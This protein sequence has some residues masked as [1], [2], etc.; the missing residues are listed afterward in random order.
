MPVLC[1][2][3]NRLGLPLADI[4]NAQLLMVAGFV[5]LG[6]VLARRQLR[7]RK[8]VNRDTRAANKQLQAMRR[9]AEPTLPLS[10]APPETQRWQV[11][12]FDLQRELKAELDTRIAIV[13]TLVRQLDE[14]IDRISAMQ[15]GASSLQPDPLSGKT[16]SDHLSAQQHQAIVDLARAGYPAKEISVRTELPIGDV[17]IVLS[18]VKLN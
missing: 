5:M 2:T 7:M 9:R 14:R 16:G 13:N 11:A 10:D 1:T 3:V 6:W 17:E 12:L 18:T 15:G 8:R 4:Q